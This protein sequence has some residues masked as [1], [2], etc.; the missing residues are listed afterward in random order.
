MKECIYDKSKYIDKYIFYFDLKGGYHNWYWHNFDLKLIE[1][2][3]RQ[4]KL[5]TIG[6][7][8]QNLSFYNAFEKASLDKVVEVSKENFLIT[9]L[10]RDNKD[11]FFLEKDFGHEWFI[12]YLN[13]DKVNVLIDEIETFGIDDIEKLL[14][15]STLIDAVLVKNFINGTIQLG[16][17][18]GY[19][20][21]LF[22][23]KE[24]VLLKNGRI[25]FLEFD[26]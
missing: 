8:Q 6:H 14:S 19:K 3:Y 26:L 10:N 2:L 23:K 11:N 9:L 7:L 13:S 25:D 24:N 1:Y 20:F 21:D 17:K 18:R 4:F 15:K 16:I 22:L 12:F 5:T